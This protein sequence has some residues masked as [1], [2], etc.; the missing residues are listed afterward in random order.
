MSKELSFPKFEDIPVSTKTFVIMMNINIDIYKLYEQ[1]PITEYTLIPKKRGRKPK[2]PVIN[3]NKDIVSGSIISVEYIDN[4]RGV[5][6][7][8]KKEKKDSEN[9]K[10]HFRNSVS[11]VIVINNK[12]INFKIS[13]NGKIQMT[14]CKTDEQSEEVMKY[15]WNYIKDTDIY[16]YKQKQDSEEIYDYFE[17]IFIPAMRN[18]D[19]S[20]G[21]HVNREELDTYINTEGKY[22]SLLETSFGY[23]GVNIKIP[24]DIDISTISIKRFIYKD[25]GVWD[26][27]Y[28]TYKYFLEML[29]PREQ[30]QKI[31]KERYNTFLVFHSGKTIMSG[32]CSETQRNTYYTFINIIKE[33]HELIEEKLDESECYSE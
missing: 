2:E 9:R 17:S 14:G 29:S 7:K 22:F 11:I 16:T 8:K 26:I 4:I 27:D 15:L 5:D 3:P 6:L 19:F 20:L 13:R 18:I 12:M 10:T 1:L 32:I 25:S 23:T 31:E 30:K 24:L 33:A 21:F 28:V